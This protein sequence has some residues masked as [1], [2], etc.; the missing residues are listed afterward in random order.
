MRVIT[1]LMLLV[2]AVTAFGQD[3]TTIQEA[4]AFIASDMMARLAAVDAQPEPK[5]ENTE[6]SQAV[7]LDDGSTVVIVQVSSDLEPTVVLLDI[8]GQ[9]VASNGGVGVSCQYIPPDTMFCTYSWD[10]MIRIVIMRKNADGVWE[11]IFDSGW[12]RD[13]QKPTRPTPTPPRRDN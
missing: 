5:A 11:L 4:D 1:G 12:F 2:A 13:R 6:V 8:G 3:V 10:G 9:V 7:T